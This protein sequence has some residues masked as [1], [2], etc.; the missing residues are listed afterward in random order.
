MEKKKKREPQVRLSGRTMIAISVIGLA[1]VAHIALLWLMPSKN[2]GDYNSG[3]IYPLM[4]Y[5]LF[6]DLAMLFIIISTILMAARSIFQQRGCGILIIFP[7]FFCVAVI[8]FSIPFYASR[9]SFEQDSSIR[10][11]EH[12]Y[13]LILAESLDYWNYP[14]GVYIVYEC[15]SLG[16]VCQYID[17]MR[18]AG[19]SSPVKGGNDAATEFYLSEDE[20][21]LYVI[22]GE[23]DYVVATQSPCDNGICD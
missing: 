1:T 8:L 4:K 17:S 18:I 3:I 2:S 10:F 12:W 21:E 20:S 6:I 15:D 13:R 5:W 11:N 19:S 7:L 23:N 14:D 22:I 16:V 9:W